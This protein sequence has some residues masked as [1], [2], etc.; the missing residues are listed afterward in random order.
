MLKLRWRFCLILW[1]SQKTSTLCSTIEFIPKKKTYGIRIKSRA[2]ASGG[3]QPPQFLAK[4]LSLSQPG[5]RLY[6]L[7][8]YEP[9]WIFRPCVGPVMT[10]GQIKGRN[11]SKRLIV[12]IKS[13][14]CFKTITST[15]TNNTSCESLQSQL[16]VA[17]QRRMH[18]LYI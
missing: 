12:L 16:P 6:P 7:Q 10:F 14:S 1:P 2:V 4:Q 9:P 8:Y 5:G 15:E 13:M 11:S 3:I 18:N 17:R